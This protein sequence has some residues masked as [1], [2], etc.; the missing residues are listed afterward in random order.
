MHTLLATMAIRASTLTR[1]SLQAASNSLNHL[2]DKG[3]YKLR[4]AIRRGDLP[5]LTNGRGLTAEQRATYDYGS[6]I[7]DGIPLLMGHVWWWLAV[8]ALLFL[9]VPLYIAIAGPLPKERPEL[10]LSC[11]GQSSTTVPHSPTIEPIPS[12]HPG[13]ETKLQHFNCK[14]I[15][16]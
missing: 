7:M 1:R 11:G 8:L 10:T 16:P 12:A 13:L 5:F 9:S 14:L 2:R 6:G 3:N 4:E 15:G